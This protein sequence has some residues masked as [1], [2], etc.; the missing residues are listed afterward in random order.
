M[1]DGRLSLLCQETRALLGDFTRLE[2]ETLVFFITKFHEEIGYPYALGGVHGICSHCHCFECYRKFFTIFE[3]FSDKK[4]KVID[5]VMDEIDAAE[6]N[7]EEEHEQEE[8][9]KNEQEE[10]VKKEKTGGKA[11]GKKK[12]SGKRS[13]RK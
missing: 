7:Q 13:S 8:E 12:A 6:G 2:I 3:S 11:G 4:K 1:I 10:G 5:Q 9:L